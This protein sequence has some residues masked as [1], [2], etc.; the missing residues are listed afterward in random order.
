MGQTY[1]YVYKDFD[2]KWMWRYF[3]PHP[4]SFARRPIAKCENPFDTQKECERDVEQLRELGLTGG[5][6]YAQSTS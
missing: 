6:Q 4:K 2:G 5:I 3:A 1:F